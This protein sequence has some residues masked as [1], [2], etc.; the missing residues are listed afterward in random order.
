MLPDGTSVDVYYYN[1]S[2]QF[3]SW[4][5]SL[6]DNDTIRILYNVSVIGGGSWILPTIPSGYDPTYKKHIT[7]ELNTELNIPLFDVEVSLITTLINPGETIVA[8]LKLLN[9][10][11]PKARVDVAATYSARTMDGKLIT[12]ATDT[13]AVTDEKEKELLLDTPRDIKP[14]RYTF[15]A[16]VTYTGREAISTRVFEVAGMEPGI[17]VAENLVYIIIVIV[18]FLTFMY[19]RMGR[20]S[21][22]PGY[23][24]ACRVQG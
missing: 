1:F 12:E 19:I 3:T 6:Y 21:R 9:V 17:P 18:A 13:F 22:R 23:G 8:V 14:G 16:L 24:N 15:E 4:D 5:G 11:G 7:T 20:R 10:G 2:Y